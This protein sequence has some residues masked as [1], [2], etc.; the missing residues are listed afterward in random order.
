MVLFVLVFAFGLVSFSTMYFEIAV[1]YLEQELKH[2][3]CDSKKY[4][5]LFLYKDAKMSTCT[6]ILYEDENMSARVRC[7][8]STGKL[9]S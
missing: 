9:G 5:R 8:G 2:L 6:K 4:S 3:L 7:L 1:H